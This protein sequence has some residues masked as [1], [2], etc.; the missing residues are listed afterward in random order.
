MESLGV[1]PSFSGH[2]VGGAVSVPTVSAVAKRVLT[3]LLV[4][5]AGDR[6][7]ARC[8]YAAGGLSVTVVNDR[9]G[10]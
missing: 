8:G 9:S 6:Y 10:V 4:V 1:V 2:V 5:N 3:P 7:D